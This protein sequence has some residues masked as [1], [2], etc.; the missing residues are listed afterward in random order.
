MN[1]P[2]S[3][4]RAKKT[5]WKTKGKLERKIDE[6]ERRG[7]QRK[8][9]LTH[10]NKHS[11]N[12]KTWE[13]GVDLVSRS[14]SGGATP[15]LPLP[16]ILRRSFPSLLLFQRKLERKFWQPTLSSPQSVPR[17]LSFPCH[18][19][20]S[21]LLTSPLLFITPSFCISPNSPLTPLLM[22]DNTKSAGCGL[23]GNQTLTHYSQACR[24]LL[25]T[26]N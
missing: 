18:F 2:G 24:L 3:K 9:S 14:R 13:G 22:P 26:L 10:D 5:K 17:F 25:C 1:T 8:S 19:I 20:L 23:N 21:F 6:E 16:Q 11:K 4:D 12:N 15:A 7:L